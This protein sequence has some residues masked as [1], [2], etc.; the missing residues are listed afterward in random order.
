MKA[1][2]AAIN[3]IKNDKINGASYLTDKALEALKNG[4]QTS[5]ARNPEE[6]LGEISDLT[7]GLMEC[8]PVMASIGNCSSRFMLELQQYSAIGPD[9]NSLREFSLLIVQSIRD[10]IAQARTET[11]EAGAGLIANGDIIMTCSYSS[12]IVQTMVR[13]H[14]QGKSF[15]TLVARSQEFTEDIAYGEKMASELCGQGIECHV[16]SD[17]DIREKAQQADKIIVGADAILLDGSLLNGYPTAELALA[18]GDAN[19]PFYTVCESHKFLRR[20]IPETIEKGFNLVP[21][22][23]ITGIVTEKGPFSIFIYFQ[24]KLRSKED[25]EV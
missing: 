11:I 14:E 10:D 9:L 17:D 4:V 13:A 18:A 19:L 12:T 1:M 6:F 8:R 21:S 23:L 15:R 16:F 7:S 20:G 24:R 3:E 22:R 2:N 5:Q 25:G